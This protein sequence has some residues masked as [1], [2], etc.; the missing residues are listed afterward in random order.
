M[1]DLSSGTA[2]EARIKR[3]E[4]AKLNRGNWETHWEEIA[5][6]VLPSHAHSFTDQS[7]TEGDKRTDEMVDA[8]A[9]LA[10]PKFAA[11]MESMLTPRNSTWHRLTALD[12]VLRRNRQVQIFFD[13]LTEI[14][15]RYRYA[16]RA[17]FSSN[18]HQ[19]YMGLGAFGTGSMFIDKLG[20]RYGGG[21]RYANNHLGT[22]YFLENHQGI[23]DTAIRKFD[24]TARQAMQ[25]FGEDLLPREIVQ[26]AEKAE[27][28]EK[29]HWFIHTVAPREESEGYDPERFDDAGMPY[30]SCYDSITGKKNLIVA[31]YNTFPYP[32]SRYIVAPGETYGRSPAM[33]AL[34][35]IKVLNEEKK[36]VLKQGHRTVDP[37]M[38]AH[39]DGVLDG[40]SLKPGSINVGGVTAEGRLLV[41]TLPTG[42]LALAGD[43]MNEERA[44][45][46]D[47][48]LLT[49]FQILVDSPQK[50]ATEV[51]ELAREKGVLL[52]PTMG[53]QQSEFQG[54]MIDREIDVL[55]QQGLLPPMPFILEQALGEY[56]VVYD[57]PLSRMQRVESATGLM[58]TI[59]WTKDYAAISGDVSPL[60]WFDW[61]KIMPDLSD[62]QAVPSRWMRDI[63]GVQGVREARAK[64]Q[65]EQQ[66][67]DAAPGLAGAL[68]ALPEGVGAG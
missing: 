4:A 15:F 31:G 53:R 2:T 24:L 59:D 66:L 19:V 43:M 64:V 7:E 8:T 16:P 62:I 34:P 6:R 32:I 39:D 46:Q 14:L 48:F 44:V 20:D 18:Q 67:L 5:R 51:L 49:L 27:T 30:K 38:L 61:D 58:R 29:R 12:P 13:D 37:V 42:D 56:E 45:I 52:S 47:A 3:F 55:N 63:K 1:A 10:L 41:H 60:D 11:A 28:V 57:S 40:F 35:A 17:G 33:L 50:T 26:D 65:Q 9:A 68:K 54:P 25:K 36:T 23:I 21:I 22:I